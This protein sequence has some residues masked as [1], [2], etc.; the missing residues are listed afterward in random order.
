MTSTAAAQNRRQLSPGRTRAGGRRCARRGTTRDATIRAT[1]LDA[2]AG[3]TELLQGYTGCGTYSRSLG[4]EGCDG[5]AHD[6][7]Q[8]AAANPS[9]RNRRQSDRLIAGSSALRPL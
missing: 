4:G 8:A 9:R 2:G 5:Q 6:Q 3:A 1:P 7:G